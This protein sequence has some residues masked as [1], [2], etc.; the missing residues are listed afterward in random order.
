M[1]N[2]ESIDRIQRVNELARRYQAGEQLSREEIAQTIKE[3]R[4]ARATASITAKTVKAKSG[5][6]AVDL[7]SIFGGLPK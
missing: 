1:S 5:K 7:D 4:S 2:Q 3:L 6:V